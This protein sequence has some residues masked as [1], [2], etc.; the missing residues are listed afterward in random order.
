MQLLEKHVEVLKWPPYSPDLNPIDNL[1][2]ILKRKV[3]K[4][5]ASSLD[6]LQEAI[7]DIWYTMLAIKLAYFFTPDIFTKD[8]SR[9]LF[10]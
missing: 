9:K 1:W 7:I 4:R 5:R 8:R 2:A 3:A 10:L 6:E